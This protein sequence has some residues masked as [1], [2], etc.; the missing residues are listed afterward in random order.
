MENS[1]EK[2]ICD[3]AY[4][5]NPYGTLVV[6]LNGEVIKFNQAF[7]DIFGVN[8]TK[9]FNFFQDMNLLNIGI[10]E[11]IKLLNVAESVKFIDIWINPKK[12][13]K[14]DTFG[15]IQQFNLQQYQ[16]SINSYLERS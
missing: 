3:E 6:D 2:E 9:T 15:N 7:C 16:Y 11:Q 4:A 8:T 12:I 14:F 13:D 1:L 5:L 10:V